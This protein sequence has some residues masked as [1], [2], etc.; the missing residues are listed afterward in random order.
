[1]RRAAWML[2]LVG[3]VA[4]A[5]TAGGS[6]YR[7][8]QRNR[9]TRSLEMYGSVLRI[10]GRSPLALPAGNLAKQTDLRPLDLFS[11]VERRLRANY[12]EKI[13][14][15]TVLAFGTADNMLDSLGDPYSRYLE[16]DQ[17]KA[18]A[19]RQRGIYRG[20][21]A[22]LDV[23][24]EQPP[25]NQSGKPEQGAP[26]EDEDSWPAYDDPVDLNSVARSPEGTPLYRYEVFVVATV[27]GGPAE[28]AGLL[29]GDVIRKV[30]GKFIFTKNLDTLERM[31]LM[32]VEGSVRLAIQREGTAKPI[33]L[34]VPM[35]ETRVDLVTSRVVDGV[36]VITIRALGLGAADGVKAKLREMA[37][38][39]VSGVV[40]DLRRNAEGTFEEACAVAS[41]F[42]P[43][44]PVAWLK[45][46]G[47]KMRAVNASAPNGR[48]EE[49][50][51]AVLI[52]DTTAGPAELVAAAVKGRG[53]GRLLGVTTR[54]R[55]GRQELFRMPGDS[56]I[57]LTT[58]LFF[59]PTAQA[60]L[61]IEGK[62]VVPDV[63]VTARGSAQ[64]QA[65]QRAIAWIKSGGA[66]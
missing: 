31:L 3:F 26:E 2:V 10:A 21:G 24:K 13:E 43:Q 54:G 58:G 59:G 16:P 35:R 6:A 14:N 47:G 23:R 46:Q 62:G 39:R 44:G 30:N 56:A 37:A 48:P 34:S 49:R 53:V 28:A 52:D 50:R 22:V 5:F 12:Y 1:M 18:Y 42:V 40:L 17:L 36:G 25:A 7:L 64:D 61:L 51:L 19:E 45:E 41:L 27:P 15:D 38:S 8:V 60:P 11:N 66:A 65:L 32:P 33:D 55:A 20:I 63:A 9:Q 29:P 4:G 57:L